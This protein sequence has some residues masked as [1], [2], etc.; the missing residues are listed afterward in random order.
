MFHLGLVLYLSIWICLLGW[1]M[2]YDENVFFPIPNW[3]IIINITLNLLF[4]RSFVVCVC[5]EF[6]GRNKVVYYPSLCDRFWWFIMWTKLIKVISVRPERSRRTRLRG[7]FCLFVFFANTKMS[8]RVCC[9]QGLILHPG[10][11]KKN[12][13]IMG[14]TEE[15]CCVLLSVVLKPTGSPPCDHKYSCC[16][17]IVPAAVMQHS[18]QRRSGSSCNNM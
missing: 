4:F 10:K 1:A 6:G 8:S 3:P 16:V 12:P 14:R 2:G 9:V 18:L 15:L 17:H 7:T 13:G 11:K 5:F